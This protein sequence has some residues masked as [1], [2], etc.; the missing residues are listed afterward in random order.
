MQ[1]SSWT[2]S[3]CD[4]CNNQIHEVPFNGALALF[5]DL[6]SLRHAQE[7]PELESAWTADGISARNHSQWLDRPKD[8]K[9]CAKHVVRIGAACFIE[10]TQ[11]HQILL[12]SALHAQQSV[13]VVLEC[14][15]D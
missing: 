1:Y 3:L 15:R 9:M 5:Q 7:V 11:G 4:I 6:I 14:T 13:A 12:L 10:V 2:H 8:K